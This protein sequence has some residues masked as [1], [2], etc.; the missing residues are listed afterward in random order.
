LCELEATARAVSA[1]KDSD[2][3]KF[4]VKQEIETA[5]ALRP[6]YERFGLEPSARARIKVPKSEPVSKWAGIVG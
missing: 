4:S 2:P 5:A 3:E 6:Y 1:K